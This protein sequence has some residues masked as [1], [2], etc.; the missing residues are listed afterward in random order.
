MEFKAKWNKHFA[1]LKDENN[2]IVEMEKDYEL[3]IK[4]RA[5]YD[6]AQTNYFRDYLF[7]ELKNKSEISLANTS[8]KIENFEIMDTCTNIARIPPNEFMIESLYID[9]VVKIFYSENGEKKEE[10]VNATTSFADEETKEIIET[11]YNVELL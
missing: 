4:E 11:F 2:V 9:A 3:Y 7:D 8:Y 6:F 5:I 1:L 10:I